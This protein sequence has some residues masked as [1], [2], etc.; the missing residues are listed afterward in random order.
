MTDVVIFSPTKSVISADELYA[1]IEALTYSGREPLNASI[2]DFLDLLSKKFLRSPL[3]RNNP[4][5]TA[6]GFWL[7]K[8][9]TKK[10]RNNFL[11][12]QPENTLLTPR[13]I[14]FHLPP[15]NV[16]TLFVYSWALAFLAGNVNIVR[17]PAKPSEVAQYLIESIIEVLVDF[18]DDKRHIFCSYDYDND[19]NASISRH[20]DLRMIWGG[21][22]K[23]NM[24]SKLP[25][26]PDGLSLGFPD[27]YSYSVIS[28]NA[29]SEC[30]DRTQ[31]ILVEN[32][33]NDL[34]WFDQMGCG[35]PR[36]L[37][38]L[39]NDDERIT[40]FSKKLSA[41]ALSKGY[42]PD[43]SVVINKFTFMND[44]LAKNI[45]LSGTAYSNALHILDANVGI[46]LRNIAPGGGMLTVVKISSLDE[47][48]KM[49]QRKD[50]TVTHFG[51]SR[52]EL[53]SFAGS[54]VGRGGYRI[55]PIGQALN[56][57]PIWDGLDLL[58]DM[59]RKIV[60]ID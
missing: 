38:W 46:D 23:V 34:F 54:I 42:E 10:I 50:Q 28:G 59:T 21:D 48:G 17:L 18:G 33:Y 22:D 25:L 40:D 53:I 12:R 56:F 43:T 15:A 20:S 11:S 6:L 27:R 30:D 49:A 45:A 55:V 36:V 3:A 58:T 2:I 32:F 47:I 39:G 37:Y 35:S 29:Y 31:N 57:G 60:V 19:I 13:G 9:A 41:K 44:M 14:A 1:R 51:F 26:R 16:D 8:A 7:R 4:Q 5:I 24:L 52:N